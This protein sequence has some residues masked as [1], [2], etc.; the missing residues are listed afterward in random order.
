MQERGLLRHSAVFIVNF[1]EIPDL[2]LLLFILILKVF[3]NVK[4][5]SVQPKQFHKA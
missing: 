4:K 3:C 5:L 2:A 1:E